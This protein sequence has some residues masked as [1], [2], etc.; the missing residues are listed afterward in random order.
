MRGAPTSKDL[1]PRGGRIGRSALFAN[2]K[3]EAVIF[4]LLLITF[5]AIEFEDAILLRTTHYTP[6]AMGSATTLGQTDSVIGGKSTLTQGA[7][8]LSWSCDLKPGFDYPYCGY[9][10]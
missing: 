6:A 5:A 8:P 10:V 7:K 2:A 1:T 4:V 3:F 9:E